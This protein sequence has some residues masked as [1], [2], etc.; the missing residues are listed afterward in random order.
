MKKYLFLLLLLNT[1]IFA[2]EELIDIKFDNLDLKEF[3]KISSKVLKKNI[4]INSDINGKIDFLSTKAIKKSQLFFILKQALLNN[5]LELKKINEIYV[6]EKL[7]EKNNEKTKE[8][9]LIKKKEIEVISLK[10]IEGKNLI[11]TVRAFIKENNLKL[12]SSLD[13]ASN[14]VVLVGSHNDM[15]LLKELIKKLDKD[16]IQ[17]YLKAK[18][19]ELN[20]SLIH[21]VGLKYGLS[22]KKISGTNLYTLSS[23]LNGTKQFLNELNSISLQIP[24]F[25]SSLALGATLNL[26]HQNYALD[27]LSEPTILCINNKKSS[28]YVGESISLQNSSTVSSGGNTSFSY[29]RKDVGLSLE[30]KPRVTDDKKVRLEIKTVLEGVKN[31]TTNNQPDT[32]K[33]EIN[34]STIVSNGESIILGGLI[35]NRV[36][37]TKDSIPVLSAIPFLGNLFTNKNK[38]KN[39]KS[40]VVIITPYIILPTQNLTLIRDELTKLEK[41]ENIFLNRKLKKIKENKDEMKNLKY[42]ELHKQR[43]KEM[44]GT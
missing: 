25:N 12:F 33:K 42:E 9:I 38:V 20:N 11:K 40:L 4:L 15:K 31:S 13:I 23:S 29:E 3:L 36:E 28:I 16:E 39:Q 6:I 27:I 10:N 19:I 8:K 32:M 2:K 35:E 24:T 17:I 41:L 1:F 5:G 7:S 18:I 30:V 22:S 34:T 37:K 14:S 43:I 26:L 21:D 44:F